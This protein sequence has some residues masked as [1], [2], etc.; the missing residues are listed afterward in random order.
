MHIGNI[1]TSI[2]QKTGLIR[3]C[4]KILGNDDLIFRSFYASILPCFEY[5]LLVW[6]T[7][8]NSHLRLLDCA[9][10]NIRLT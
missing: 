5:C 6:C 1:A 7:G 9:L 2:A 10:G 3:K 4:F 8:S